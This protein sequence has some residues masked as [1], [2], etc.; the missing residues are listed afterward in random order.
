MLPKP[1]LGPV[2]CQTPSHSSPFLGKMGT[3]PRSRLPASHARPLGRHPIETTPATDPPRRTQLQNASTCMPARNTSVGHT[4]PSSS[5]ARTAQR[6][7]P[8]K[9][10]MPMRARPSNNGIK[11]VVRHH[12][13]RIAHATLVGK[14][15]ILGLG[16]W[17]SGQCAPMAVA[18]KRG[19]PRTLEPL[20]GK[21]GLS[22]PSA[23]PPSNSTIS[24]SRAKRHAHVHAHPHAYARTRTHIFTFPDL[25]ASQ[26]AYTHT[27][28]VEDAALPCLAS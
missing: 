17:K 13:A 22:V 8:F 18:E 25:V 21:M 28:K 19:S 1:K 26:R 5:R 24:R 7:H 20:E 15:L 3:T 2:S 10:N 6:P 16:S 4:W 12:V 9:A 23:P 14:Q 11:G 27:C